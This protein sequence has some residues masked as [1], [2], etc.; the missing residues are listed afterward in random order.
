MIECNMPQDILKYEAKF[1]GN[2]TMRQ[3]IWGGAGL[4]GALIGFFGFFSGIADVTT[5]IV[6]SATIA[7]PFFL[8]GFLKV[9]GQPVEKSVSAILMDN[10]IKPAKR[11]Y[12]RE[13]PMLTKWEKHRSFQP[14]EQF[15]SPYN[16]L[17]PEEDRLVKKTL[18]EK[19]LKKLN[20][21]KNFRVK[22]SPEYPPVY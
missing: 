18:T 13:Y 8:I 15:I 1:V 9:Y 19:E 22:G 3:T 17:L 21:Q 20:K 10:F 7:I 5:R 12:K 4:A 2:F 14:E 6:S 16:D 11:P